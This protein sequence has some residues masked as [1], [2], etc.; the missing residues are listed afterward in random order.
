MPLAMLR[1]GALAWGN[2]KGLGR[3]LLLW[4]V[5]V[6]TLPVLL[7]LLVVAALAGGG[8]SATPVSGVP[9]PSWVVTQQYG[10]TGSGFEPPRGDCAHFHYGIDLAAPA[11]TAVSAVGPGQAEVFLPTG[12]GG[13][14]GLHVVVRHG[15][16]DETLYGHLQDVAIASGAAVSA[17]T[18]LGHEG[19]TGLST[20]PHLHFEV[21]EAGVAVD[22][23]RAFAGIFG[24][25]GQK[26]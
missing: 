1:A 20:G 17:G 6:L 21:R 4:S 25:D 23:T 15:G 22:P 5:A 26:R 7:A 18:V 24:P 13:G 14:Y 10:C 19:S 2:R 8:A 3:L 9:M 12:P 11:G 16:G